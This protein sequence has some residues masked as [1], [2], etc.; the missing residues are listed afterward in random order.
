MIRSTLF[1]FLLILGPY[2]TAGVLVLQDGLNG[3]F[4]TE[5]TQIK[6]F[7][8]DTNFGPGGT[9]GADAGGIQG[10]LR[11]TNLIGTGVNQIDAGVSVQSAA[12]TL[13]V[14]NSSSTNPT[15]HQML[16]DWNE[17]GLT[18]NNAAATGNGT[19]GF[20]A[21][22][23][24]AKSASIGAFPAST[25]GDAV[26]DI[27]DVVQNWV[28]GEANH[29]L[30]FLSSSLDAAEFASSNNDFHVRPRLVIEYTSVPAP[31]GLGIFL[32]GLMAIW[33]RRNRIQNP[34]G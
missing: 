32:L 9:F 6:L 31:A 25:L 5:E 18:W 26:L 22:N 13:H 14:T 28:N 27:T 34:A 30:L 29:G 1:A 11:F 3:H 12:L 4:S 23:I 16:V 10:L 15:V 20:Q 7:N 33:S 24:D 2:A 17:N 19:A 21:D 8:P